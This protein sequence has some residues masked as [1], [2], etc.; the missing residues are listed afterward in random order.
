MIDYHR[1]LYAHG[2]LTTIRKISISFKFFLLYLSKKKS[3][4]L[5]FTP[6]NEF[7]NQLFF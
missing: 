4:F 6:K 2:Y 1:D 7:G 5:F 3:I